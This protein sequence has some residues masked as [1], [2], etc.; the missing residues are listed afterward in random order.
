MEPGSEPTGT[1]AHTVAP[2]G[3]VD[4]ATE[5]AVAASARASAARVPEDTARRSRRT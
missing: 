1:Y 4:P 3:A 2:A 5:T